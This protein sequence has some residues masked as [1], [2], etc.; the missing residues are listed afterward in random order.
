MVNSTINTTYNILNFDTGA[1]IF[2]GVRYDC[3]QYI[4][5]HALTVQL[6]DERVFAIYVG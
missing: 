4:K 6:V 3:E 2:T 5:E 1:R